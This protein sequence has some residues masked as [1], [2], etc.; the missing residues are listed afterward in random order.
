MFLL[1]TSKKFWSH[2]ILLKMNEHLTLSDVTFP[3]AV[4]LIK[5]R[6]VSMAEAGSRVHITH[7]KCCEPTEVTAVEAA[8][9]LKI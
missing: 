5:R 6:L 9:V 3:R 2:E 8:T 1:G 4:C 7:I